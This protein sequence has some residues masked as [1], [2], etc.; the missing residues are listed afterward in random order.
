MGWTGGVHVEVDFGGEP[1]VA[2]LTE[3]GGDVAQE[4]GFV[5][6]KGGDAGSA[7]EFLT[8]LK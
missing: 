3:E 5:G 6:E 7:F 8:E 4:G 2:L 1:L